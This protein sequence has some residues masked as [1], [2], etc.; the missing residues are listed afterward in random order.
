[1]VASRWLLVL[2]MVVSAAWVGLAIAATSDEC[3]AQFRATDID[4]DEVLSEAEI[5]SAATFPHQLADRT[6]VRL[7]E[8]MEACEEGDLRKQSGKAKRSQ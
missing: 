2:V 8:Y 4:K 6:S 3:R 7:E 1:M 5:A